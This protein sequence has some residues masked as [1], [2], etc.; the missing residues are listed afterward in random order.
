MTAIEPLELAARKGD[1]EREQK[2]C[3]LSA[4]TLKR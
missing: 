3:P 4:K 2:W 1:L